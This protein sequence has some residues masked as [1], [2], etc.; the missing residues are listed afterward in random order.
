MPGAYTNLLY[1]L[2]FSTKERR[3]L[4]DRVIKPQLCA[5]M[6]GIVRGENGELLEINGVANHLHL[7]VRLRPTLAIADAL[8][9]YKTN[10]SKWANEEFRRRSRFEWQEGY[11]AFTVSQSQAPRLV[12]YIQNQEEHHR[13]RN[14]RS[15]LAQLLKRHGIA[16]EERHL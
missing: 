11:A 12:A 3:P 8:R 1:H 2:V 15:E 7:L 10:S 5:Y 9:I 13:K 16:F 4:I 6:G 14:F